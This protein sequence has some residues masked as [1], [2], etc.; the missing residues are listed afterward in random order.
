[1][2]RLYQLS[3]EIS[4]LK[5]FTIQALQDLTREMLDSQQGLAVKAELELKFAMPISRSA[6][7]GRG[8][9]LRS[10][11]LR[12]FS[13]VDASGRTLFEVQI[14]VLYSSTC[15]QSKALSE[16]VLMDRLKRNFESKTLNVDQKV[17]LVEV[18][19]F[20]KRQG[21]PATPHAQRSELTLRGRFDPHCSNEL[22]VLGWIKQAIEELESEMATPVQTFVKKADE[23]AFAEK[24]AKHSKFCE[25]AARAVIGWFKRAEGSA[26]KLKQIK[27]KVVHF[28]SLHP[29]NAVARFFAQ[30]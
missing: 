11:P 9:G 4:S 10:Y 5:K 28:E 12:I 29:F 14:K 30:S 19:E 18:L 23:M 25:D 1:M 13:A 20:I 8:Q 27:G 24:N 16:F 17:S 2:S 3:Q 21:L 7:V 26:A 22:L 6:I 15:P